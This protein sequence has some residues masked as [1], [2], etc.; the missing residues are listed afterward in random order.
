MKHESIH[1]DLDAPAARFL[2]ASDGISSWLHGDTYTLKLSQTDTGG[3]FSLIEATVPPGGGPPMHIHKNED[4]IFYVLHGELD[5]TAGQEHYKARSGDLV[6]IPKN[7]PHCF[8]NNGLHAAKQLLIFTPAGFEEFFAEAGTP[9][10]PGI[11]PPAFD[12][13]NNQRV[14]DVG[15]KYH[16]EQL[17]NPELLRT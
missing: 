3:R 2:S 14:I 6:F 9:A 11:V 17:P 16:A 10:S 8:R 13:D 1:T 7:I 5:V 4:E 15:L 12:P